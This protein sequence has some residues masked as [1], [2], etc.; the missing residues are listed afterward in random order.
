MF[1]NESFVTLLLSLLAQ[2]LFKVTA[3]PGTSCVQQS[4]MALEKLSEAL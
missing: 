2:L 1:I 3:R 4:V